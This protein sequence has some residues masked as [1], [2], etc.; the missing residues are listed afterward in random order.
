MRIITCAQMKQAEQ[1]AY[2]E[3]IAPLRLMENAGAAAAR[4]I[5]DTVEVKGAAFVVLCGKGN[6]GG[7][8][9]VVARK[10]F[11]NGAEVAALLACGEPE[12]PD[13]A[14]MFGRL[15]D[16]N[17]PVLD[18]QRQPKQ[19][20]EVLDACVFI[21]DAVFGTGF[22]GDVAA[23]LAALFDAAN[24][25]GAK[26]FSIDMPSGANADTGAAAAVCI[27]A[28]YTVTFAAPKT[29]QFTFPAAESCG[30]IQ[31]VDI[32]IP[33][34]A[35]DRFPGA[36]EL[37]EQRMVASMLPVRRRDSSKIDYGRLLCVCGCEG[38]TGAAALSALGALRSG[39]G[40]VSLAVPRSVYPILA[41]KL[42]EAVVFPAEATP[43]GAFSCAAL[44]PLL[45]AAK[46]A[47]A[48]LIGCG[49]SRDAETVRLV[50][51]L[52]AAAEGP[53]ILDADGINAF[54][55]HIDLLR[56]T[57]ASLVLT[58]HMGEMARLTGKT[59]AEIASNRLGEATAL[60]ADLKATVVLKGAN[61]V[62]AA[63][64][65][66]SYIN[67]TGNAGMARGGAG[68]VLAGMTA[69]FCAQ[70]ISPDRAA[71]CA[72]YLHGLTGDRCAAKL[73]QYG[74]LPSD[75]LAELPLIFRE[76][77]R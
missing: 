10:L 25:S 8:G 52:V 31:T 49:L 24:R 72:V 35:F 26:I 28:D 5:R 51:A 7:D 6:N 19:C 58:P 27:R 34:D 65:G 23:P 29:G 74:M 47:T 36:V 56:E 14:E 71:C 32:G 48:L 40:L 55:G 12:T 44:E 59:T 50:R 21:V 70:G 11:E 13:A 43:S 54:E 1:A 60:A 16:L 20:V 62:V 63:P 57:K 38:F 67:P 33:G 73:S 30:A 37:L 15:R 69:S 17:I 76:L 42:N 41:A 45:A 46:K 39:A 9:F 64:D 77:G 22:R 4:F 66:K 18:Y 3:G 75:L 53:V 68:D 61:T 2:E